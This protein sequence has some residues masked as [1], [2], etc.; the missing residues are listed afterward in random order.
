MGSEPEF[1]VG[2][3]EVEQ[4]VEVI[5]NVRGTDFSGYSRASFTRRIQRIVD[6]DASGK[7][8]ALIDRL[9]NGGEYVD[10]FINEVTVNVTEM[11]RD[12]DFFITLRNTVIPELNR[13]NRIRIWHAGCSTGEEVYSMAILLHEAGCLDKAEIIAT[14]LNSDALERASKGIFPTKSIAEYQ[15]NYANIKGSGNLSDYY[16]SDYKTAT[17]HDF[18]R[19][20]ITFRKHDLV[21]DG[22]FGIFDLI[23]CRNVLIY[24]QKP[25]Q[26]SVIRL[27]T[28]SL[29]KRGF[30]CLGTK[31]SLLFAEDRFAYTEMDWKEKIYRKK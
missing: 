27:F 7:F 10:L 23:V 25:L 30:L 9:N 20:N 12:P 5:R 22:V 21:L 26:S 4:I 3:E 11:F 28:E 15:R 8:D 2:E 13:L 18:L 31:E 1:E 29:D 6:R 14:D 19:S 24:F 17:F 16:N